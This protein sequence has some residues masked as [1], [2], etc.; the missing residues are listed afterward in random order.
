MIKNTKEQKLADFQELFKKEVVPILEKFEHYRIKEY[1]NIKRTIILITLGI[2]VFIYFLIIFP[3]NKDWVFNYDKINI[4]YIVFPFFLMYLYYPVYI[5]YDNLKKKNKNFQTLLKREVFGKILNC[6][7]DI[8]WFSNENTDLQDYAAGGENKKFD[9]SGLFVFY[10]RRSTDDT[11][12]CLVKNVYFTVTETKMYFTLGKNNDNDIK[13]YIPTFKGIIIEFESN[14]KIQNRTIVSTKGDLTTKSD[15]WIVVL[16]FSIQGLNTV[17]TRHGFSLIGLIIHLIFILG[18][19]LIYLKMS[20]TGEKLEPVMLESPEFNKKF[21][22]YS[23]DQVEAR[24]LVTTS[25][26]ERFQNLKTHFGAKKAK[27]SFY[28]GNKIMFAIHTN[29][30]LFEL[31][32]LYH[33][34][35]DSKSHMDLFNTLNSIFDMI[36]YFKLDEKTGL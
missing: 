22:V 35:L 23:S 14:K 2:L 10:D 36:E 30:D 13:F 24:Y 34:L 7:G 5:Y 4:S 27:C 1:K 28:D 12:T 19:I 29:K 21:N 20:K 15:I 31:G 17:F 25:F 11:F 26:M 6:I 18:I 9:A 32:D 33:P 8:E 3:F 16:I